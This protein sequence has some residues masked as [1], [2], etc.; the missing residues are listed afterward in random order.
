MA[1]TTLGAA[2]LIAIDSPLAV[3]GGMAIFGFG[4]GGAQNVTLAMMFD[5]TS[6]HEIGKVSA[7]WNLV[8]DGGMGVGAVGFG[9]LTVVTGYPWGFASVAAILAAAVVVAVVDR[10]REHVTAAIPAAGV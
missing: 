8:F 5:R 2:C 10:P 1:L 9:Y 4:Y 6:P 7:L 3:I